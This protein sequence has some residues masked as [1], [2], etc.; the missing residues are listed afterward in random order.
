MTITFIVKHD[1]NEKHLSEDE[2]DSIAEGC[3][4]AIKPLI[5]IGIE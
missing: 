5:I 1:E 4:T 3:R 2:F